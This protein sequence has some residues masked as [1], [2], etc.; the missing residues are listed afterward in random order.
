[1]RL[2]TFLMLLTSAALMPVA[3]GDLLYVGSSAAG[4]C[5][6]NVNLH[7][8]SSSDVKV[9]VSLT[10]GATA[11][12]DTGN[13]S[14]HPG[15]AFSIAN[16]PAISITNI[17]SPWTATDVHLSSVTVNGNTF[18]TFDYF[19]DNVGSGGSLNNPGPLSFD[20]TLG[21]GLS[22]ND[23]VSNAEGYFFV[24]DI[25][26]AKGK[27]GMSGINTNSTTTSTVP[28]PSAIILLGTVGLALMSSVRRRFHS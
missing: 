24:A 5:C 21:A 9:T 16:H 3:K 19:I 13:G 17:S 22:I 11:F 12:V 2:P 27:T 26:D 15:F 20:A 10:G 8:V 25:L 4:E 18:G 6:F 28:E 23:F 14:N 1:M 7:Q